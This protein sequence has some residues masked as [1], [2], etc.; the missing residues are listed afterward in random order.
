VDLEPESSTE[1]GIEI[2]IVLPNNQRQPRTLP[3]QTD[4]LSYA[5]CYS[6]CPVSAALVGFY[7]MDSS[8]TFFRM[9]LISTSGM[10]SISTSY[11]GISLKRNRPLPSASIGP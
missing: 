8:S 2:G 6:L 11:R 9:E 7:R 5:L 4:A 10:D 3:A 1:I